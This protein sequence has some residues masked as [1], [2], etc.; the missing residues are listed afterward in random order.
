MS[1]KSLAGAWN[2]FFFEPVSPVP[3]ALFRIVF[4]LVVLGDV[5]LL[6]PEWPV[7][8]GPRGLVTLETM[9][10][11][12]PGTRINVFAIV[13]QTEFW[14]NAVFWVLLVSA[15]FLTLG[16][17]SRASSVAVFVAV[18]SLHERNLYIANSG[19][20]LLRV[21]AFFLMFAP[22]GAALSLDRL[23]QIW[24]G[25]QG[26]EL[27][28]RAPW[29]Q[30]MIQIEVALLYLMTFWNKSQGAAW[31]DGS[32]L[33]Y[34]YH[35]DQFRRFP[36]PGFLQDLLLVRLETWFT[37]AV[38]F[39]LG[40]LVWFRELRYCV[41]AL[42]VVLHLSLEYAMNV[43]MFQWTV[44]AIYI[45]FV[46]GE[47]LDRVWSRIRSFA[48]KHMTRTISVGFDPSHLPGGRG[49]EVLQALDVFRR[50]HLVP[51]PGEAELALRAAGD[52]PAIALHLWGLGQLRRRKGRAVPKSLPASVRTDAWRAL[53]QR[54]S[55]HFPAL[56]R[57]EMAQFFAQF[58]AFVGEDGDC[59][60]RRVARARRP[61]RQCADGDASGHLH[62]RQQRIQPLQGRALH[63][64]AQ[65]R[66]QGV[67]GAYSG[68]VRRSAGRGN[69]HFQ[70]AG[71]RFAHIFRGLVRGA[72][73]GEHPAFMRNPESGKR[74]VGLA[75]GR[76]VRF[77]AHDDGDQGSGVCHG[78]IVLAPG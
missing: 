12:E 43:P 8:F 32:A 73:R 57:P 46:E 58:R 67:R 70:S 75:H 50:L 54:L 21:T 66:Q 24:R 72:V 16:L 33:Y 28:P 34:M 68:Q 2:R 23:R 13:P 52:I 3:I 45:T 41:L 19:D 5:L 25:R 10:Q 36:I 62:G 40:V 22:T 17:F 26:V 20:T 30:R 51:R 53:R 59:Q 39:S 60:K 69:Y 29:A 55:Q 77:A 48:S 15:L 61:D 35:L 78:V 4:G 14:S 27:R 49:A 6:R 42:G 9:Q 37:L 76:P 38:E 31:I 56:L 44:L 1:L 18:A 64:H 65:H 63:G 71:F 7:W 74:F 47:D 11:M